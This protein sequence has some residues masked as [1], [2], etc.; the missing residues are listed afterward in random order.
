VSAD[1]SGD[2]SVEGSQGVEAGRA[3]GD[4]DDDEVAD[5]EIVEEEP[6][7]AGGAG[8]PT[9]AAGGPRV[10][11]GGPTVAAGG[12]RVLTVLRPGYIWKGRVIRPAMVRVQG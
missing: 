7:G 8:G 9:V 12:P 5:A 10:S 1:A 6:A 2:H 11:A 3:V 4:Y